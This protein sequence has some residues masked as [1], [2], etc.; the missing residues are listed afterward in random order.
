MSNASYI[1]LPEDDWALNGTVTLTVGT[2]DSD[3]LPGWLVDGR[4]GRPAR[5]TSGTATFQ[6]TNPNGAVECV[7]VV[8]H[9]IDGART[10]T[11]G[12]DVSATMAAPGTRPNGIP[13]NPFA[14]VTATGSPGGVDTLTVGV[15]SNSRD[16]VIGEVFAGVLRAFPNAG[17]PGS[18][19][20]RDNPTRD[21]QNFRLSN[22]G[23]FGSV[24]PYDRGIAGDTFSG[25]VICTTSE[26]DDVWGWYDA[27]KNGSLP[28]V[29]I[30]D[31][32][33]QD[34]RVVALLEPS[35]VAI[36]T[37]L[38]EVKLTFQEYPRSRW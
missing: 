6:I 19:L 27:Q 3:Y 35:A 7:V 36:T 17:L 11:L 12:G 23:E 22:L 31:D 24:P 16:L 15:S 33:I 18:F 34:A 21:R 30:L 32:T 38:Y 9:N 13:Y 8:N 29:I 4:S 26:L 2:I 1:M 5:A 20:L 37:D 28:L 14:L 25:T 10:I